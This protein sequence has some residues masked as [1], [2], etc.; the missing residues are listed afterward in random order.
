[1]CIIRCL[2]KILP[3]NLGFSG[4]QSRNRTSDTRIFNPLLYQLSYPGTKAIG[5]QID[6][7]FDGR[8][9]RQRGRAVQR[10]LENFCSCDVALGVS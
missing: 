8:V 7:R 1:M 10:V 4:A 3:I 2:P 9:I 6:N 5:R